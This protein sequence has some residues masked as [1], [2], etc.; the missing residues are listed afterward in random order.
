M[1]KVNKDKQLKSEL[2][3]Y[4]LTYNNKHKYDT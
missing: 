1:K 3:K 4:Q 2:K